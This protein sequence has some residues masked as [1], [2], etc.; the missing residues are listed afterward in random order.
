M[1]KKDVLPL[2]VSY[3]DGQHDALALDAVKL[4]VF[5]TL[6]AETGAKNAIEQSACV[7]G[8]LEVML[9]AKAALFP[10]LFARLAGPLERYESSQMRM[11][12]DDPKVIQLFLTLMRNLLLAAEPS[13]GVKRGA[14]GG[15]SHHARARMKEELVE[16]LEDLR[17]TR[18]L[19]QMAK[20]ARRKPF[21]ED[22][23]LLVEIFSL[24]FD[25]QSPTELAGLLLAAETAA[26]NPDGDGSAPEAEGDAFGDD[27]AEDEASRGEKRRRGAYVDAKRLR[28]TSI[29]HGRFG[30]RS[31]R[32][33]AAQVTAGGKRPRGSIGAA[34]RVPS[35]Y[36]GSLPSGASSDARRTNARGDGRSASSDAR[37]AARDAFGGALNLATR[38]ALARLADDLSAGGF[39]EIILA[40]WNQLRHQE[41]SAAGS[42]E[43]EA[44]AFSFMSLA[45]FFLRF[46]QERLAAK[47]KA[48]AT[49]S[50]QASASEGGA[51][52]SEG[53]APA[54][55]AAPPEAT[56]A[57]SDESARLAS[58]AASAIVSSASN[59]FDKHVFHWVRMAWERFEQG[60]SVRGVV[61]VSG[62]AKE[63]LS[64]LDLVLTLGSKADVF[65]ARA[66]ASEILSSDADD[67]YVRFLQSCAKRFDPG[68]GN[69]TL[70]GGNRGGQP[71]VVYLANVV[72]A[73]HVARRLLPRVDAS[74]GG[75]KER[76]RERGYFDQ[77]AVA[78][79]VALIAHWALNP[80]RLNAHL[81]EYVRE[82]AA[83]EMETSLH[84]LASLEIFYGVAT[85]EATREGG[86]EAAGRRGARG[87][88]RG[89]KEIRALRKA[90]QDVIVGFVRELYP[91]EDGADLRRAK[92]VDLVF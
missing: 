39:N 12:D 32:A 91:S 15:E 35:E 4:L 47:A 92:Y 78:N 56:P 27:D 66:L 26:K 80:P 50:A 18:L 49:P 85:A 31:T 87:E 72:E 20:D 21:V 62:L 84:D 5:L 10:V 53:G 36:F 43:Y 71:P 89:A 2:L 73:L 24:L 68:P 51:P 57:E 60:K 79:R 46:A 29:R 90:A 37:G 59:L 1:L 19:A 52:A 86:A 28:A 83:A 48:E 8:A 82:L 11:R 77:S 23:S 9:G 34:A 44:R 40:S 63:M 41:Q 14:E 45:H 30:G 58:L 81:A 61:L 25:G 70:R 69:G 75:G 76:G 16:A 64:F 74:R 17:V 88:V 65:A 7:K 33:L 55:E 13:Q 67:D 3:H 42:E 54:S 22:S 38:E 6:P